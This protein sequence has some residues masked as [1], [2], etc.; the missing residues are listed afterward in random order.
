MK[1]PVREAMSDLLAAV[2][3]ELRH[4]VGSQFLAPGEQVAWDNC[5]D[6]GNGGG[7]Q[8]WVRCISVF[9][10][11]PKQDS[12]Q[13]CNVRLATA[14]LGVGIVRCAHTLDDQ[15]NAPSGDDMTADATRIMEDM[16][17]VFSGVV[18]NFEWTANIGQWM[19]V[20][21]DGGCA[22]GEWSVSVRL[23]P[24]K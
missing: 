1:L 3:V 11:W 10:G 23:Q 14:V 18:E 22:G 5:C 21:P 9:P 7:G 12:D 13:K 19:P 17:D 8:L 20:G 6:D 2:D 15:G 16:E 4:E 24:C